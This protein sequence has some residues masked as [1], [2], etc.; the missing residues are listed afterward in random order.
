MNLLKRILGTEKR[1]IE[2]ISSNLDKIKKELVSIRDN[3]NRVQALVDLTI[4]K[5]LFKGY[6]FELSINKMVDQKD[7]FTNL[8][9]KMKSF[10]AWDNRVKNGK[11]PSSKDIFL[12]NIYG[13]WTFSAND[14][15]SKKTPT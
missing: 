7:N 5:W 13:I 3:E 15:L 2:K 4:L 8:C 6:K 9:N 14:W 11:R 1:E 10:G 12:G